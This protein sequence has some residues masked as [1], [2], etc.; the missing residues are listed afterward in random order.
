MRNGKSLNQT[1][2]QLIETFSRSLCGTLHTRFNRYVLVDSRVCF[3]A[4]CPCP[5]Q[6]TRSSERAPIDLHLT[7]KRKVIKPIRAEPTQ[8]YSMRLQSVKRAPARRPSNP[9]GHRLSLLCAHP[10]STP[11]A[12]CRRPAA[13]PAY[14]LLCM[15]LRHIAGCA[16][17]GNAFAI[18]LV[19]VVTNTQKLPNSPPL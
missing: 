1:N 13:K 5:P 4:I 11:S 16:V 2:K 12:R 3:S 9:R 19:R 18:Q 15:P 8:Y 7:T 6:P 14:C 17:A 10:E